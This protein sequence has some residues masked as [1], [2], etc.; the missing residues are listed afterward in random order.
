MRLEIPLHIVPQLKISTP[1]L[2]SL[3]ELPRIL[4]QEEEEAYTKTTQSSE[5]DVVSQIH[6]GSGRIILT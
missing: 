6:N 3:V 1:C 2:E 4:G 5:L